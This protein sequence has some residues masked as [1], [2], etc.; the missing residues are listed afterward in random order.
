M[1]SLGVGVLSGLIAGGTTYF[2]AKKN[3]KLAIVGAVLGGVAGY[4]VNQQIAKRKSTSVSTMN[5]NRME[6]IREDI[7]EFDEYEEQPTFEYNS[8]INKMMPVGNV[9]EINSNDGFILEEE[10]LDVGF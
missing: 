8:S 9:Q 3:W 10:G 1:K 4:L 5:N 6:D 7:E 2:V